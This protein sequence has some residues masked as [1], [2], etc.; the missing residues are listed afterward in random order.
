MLPTKIMS[1][2]KKYVMATKKI[3]WHQKERLMLTKYV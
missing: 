3:M 2:T 1:V